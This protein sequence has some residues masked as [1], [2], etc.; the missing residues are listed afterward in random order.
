MK[1]IRV[2]LAL[3][4][5]DGADKDCVGSFLVYQHYLGRLQERIWCGNRMALPDAPPLDPAD[6]A[7][8]FPEWLRGTDLEFM[9]CDAIGYSLPGTARE[10]AIDKCLALGADYILFYDADMIFTSD[11]FLKLLRHQ[12]PV[13]AALAFTGREPLTPVLYEFKTRPDG[14]LESSPIHDYKRDALQQVGAVGFGVV[15]IQAS[16]FRK[17][18]KPWFSA[19]GI[20]EDIQFAVYC[21]RAGIPIYADT[22]AKAIHKPRYA[23]EWHSEEKY[24]TDRDPVVKAAREE[25]ERVKAERWA[26]I[27]GDAKALDTARWAGIKEIE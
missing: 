21:Q 14:K 7:A 20:G 8:E 25:F 9:L 10:V 13:V 4:W 18:P 23:P 24:L 1:T 11:V 17:L 27:K 3:P 16:V 12:L 26:I 15:L 5:Y 19:P 22:S 6:P 2:A